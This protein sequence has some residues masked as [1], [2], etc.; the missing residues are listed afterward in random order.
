MALLNKQLNARKR[1]LS[2]SVALA[3]VLGF[4]P[5]ANAVPQAVADLSANRFKSSDAD[6]SMDMPLLIQLPNADFNGQLA[7]SSHRSHSSHSSHR[8]HSS[9]SSGYGGGYG[10]TYS[11]GSTLVPSQSTTVPAPAP[12]RPAPTATAAYSVTVF[13]V[14]LNDG[15]VYRGTISHDGDDLLIKSGMVTVRVANSNVKSIVRGDAAN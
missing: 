11:G 14:T 13:V 7:H 3:T 6:E 1:V 9:H 8:S 12:V 10:G 15:T 4:S 5:S 2:L